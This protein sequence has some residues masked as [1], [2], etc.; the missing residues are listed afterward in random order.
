MLSELL[1]KRATATGG[2][3]DGIVDG[4]LTIFM[5]QPGVDI[6]PALL[7]DLLAKDDRCRSGVG[8]EV[9]FR[10]DAAR[11]NSGTAIIAEME[12]PSLDAEPILLG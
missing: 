10:Y 12:D 4:D 9:V 11:S 8:E 3:I 5:V 6:F 7:E 2:G 1:G